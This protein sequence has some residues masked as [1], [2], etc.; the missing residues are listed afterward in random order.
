VPGRAT[1]RERI[2]VELQ[3]RVV[4]RL[5]ALSLVPHG[6]AGRTQNAQAHAVLA[7]RSRRLTRSSPTSL[8]RCSTSTT[9]GYPGTI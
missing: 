8:P 6:V 3:D 2:A 4:Q 9:G 1:E 5:F 7:T